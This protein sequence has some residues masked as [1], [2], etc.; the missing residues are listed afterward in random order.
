[1]T[2]ALMAG[3]AL[4]SFVPLDPGN[5]VD[6]VPGGGAFVG[7][8]VLLFFAVI[9]FGIWRMTVVNSA[10]KQLGLTDEQRLLAVTDEQAGAAIVTGAII[11]DAIAGRPAADGVVP[12]L[13]T[14]LASLQS[15]LEQG[16]ISQDEFTSTRQR[17]LDEA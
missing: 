16:L 6:L 11:S 3:L 10:S 17:M 13:A 2:D 15:A 8:F 5:P 9:G 14:R 4:D 1:M 7:L 12:D